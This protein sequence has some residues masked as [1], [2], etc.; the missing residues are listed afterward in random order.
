MLF[1]IGLALS[2]GDCSRIYVV[3]RGVAVVHR[4][5][6]L[7]LYYVLTSINRISS[8]LSEFGIVNIFVCIAAILYSI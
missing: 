2:N 4:N 6:L 1:A 3:K 5:H 8:D 7:F